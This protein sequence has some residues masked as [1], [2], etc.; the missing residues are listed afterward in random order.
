M[1][2]K[3]WSDASST[4]IEWFLYWKHEFLSLGSSFESWIYV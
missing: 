1:M 4:L 2:M 3:I